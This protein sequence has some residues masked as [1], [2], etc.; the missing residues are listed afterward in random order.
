[1][2]NKIMFMKRLRGLREGQEL[3]YRDL[4]SIVNISYQALHHYEIGNR[5]PSVWAVKKVANY[6]NVS[7]DWLVGD[8]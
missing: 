6:F 8:K 2:D 1:M 3:T 5:D 7:I 4:A